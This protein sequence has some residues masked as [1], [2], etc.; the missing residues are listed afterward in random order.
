MDADTRP[1]AA[2]S[3]PPNEVTRLLQDASQGNREAFDS[4][5]PLVYEELKQLASSRLQLESTGHTLNATA[6]VHEVYLRLAEQDRVAWQSRAHFFALAAQAMRRIL[7]NHAKSRK[8]Q[9]RG[10]G[11]DHLSLSE[12]Q[13]GVLAGLLPDD[14]IVDLLALDEALQTLATFNPQGADV[15]QYR[16]FGGLTHTEIAEV[17]GTSEVTI[18]R[19]W[20]A[21]KSW[22]RRELDADGRVG[23]PTVEADGP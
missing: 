17:M 1:S 20:S 6:L 23:E 2:P 16:F 11:A 15:V 13:Q 21:A 12:A 14:R 5:F 10:G 7:I 8:R 4:L 18:R 19:R 3:T 9:K 22:L